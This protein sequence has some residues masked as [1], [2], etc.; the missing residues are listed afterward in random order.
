MYTARRQVTI[1]Q[2]AKYE[3]DLM[4]MAEK[5]QNAYSGTEI[6]KRKKRQYNN[7]NKCLPDLNDS[8]TT[9]GKDASRK[10]GL[11]TWFKMIHSKYI[12]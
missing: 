10:N 11:W 9:S 8:D 7:R 4:K 1:Y 12:V 6:K 5:S 3:K 2:L